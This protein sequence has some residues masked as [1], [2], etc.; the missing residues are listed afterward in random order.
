MHYYRRH[1]GDYA[2]K[3]GHLSMLEHGA[4]NL[5]LDAYYDREVAPTRTEAIRFARA[6]SAQEI[7]A[8]DAVLAEFFTEKDGRFYQSRVESEFDE[9]A[10]QAEKN[11]ENGKRGGRPRKA[12]PSTLEE[13]KKTQ[14]VSSGFQNETQK[15]P[16][17]LIQESTNPIKGSKE[18]SGSAGADRCPQ[19][20]LISLYHEV[21]PE[22]PPVR[23]WPDSCATN[24]RTRWRSQP[25]RQSLDWWRGF[26]NY[27]RRCPF[28]MGERGD[29]QAS[30]MWL[31]GAKNFAKVLNGNYEDRGRA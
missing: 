25:D 9:A 26:F 24:L 12:A 27:V 8:V 22:L 31:V 30:L 6:R 20:E 19:Q 15:N 28:L 16:N 21:L 23:D 4:Y 10:T 18:P 5:I 7:A 17:P 29:F 13:P 1:L 11:R 14:P 2:R 3:A